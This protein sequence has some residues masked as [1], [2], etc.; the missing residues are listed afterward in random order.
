[1]FD[2]LCAEALGPGQSADLITRAAAEVA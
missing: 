1:V 2:H